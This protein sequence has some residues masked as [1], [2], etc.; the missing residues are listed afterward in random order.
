[1]V[2]RVD[3]LSRHGEFSDV[4]LQLHEGEILGIA[5]LVG[6]GRTELVKCI[7]GDT[8]PH[9]G[10]VFVNGVK[11]TPTA[12][13]G[14]DPERHRLRAGGAPAAWGCSRSSA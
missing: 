9:A 4:S 5:G 2:L 11:V 7:F 13:R 3:H 8:Q 6:A 12:P 1:M 14:R 10:E